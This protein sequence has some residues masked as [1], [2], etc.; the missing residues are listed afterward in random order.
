MEEMTGEIVG[1]VGIFEI[2]SVGLEAGREEGVEVLAERAGDEL[3][4]EAKLGIGH[5]R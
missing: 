2:G 5:G 1:G 4:V 3:V